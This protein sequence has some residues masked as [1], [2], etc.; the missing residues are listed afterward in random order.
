MKK[1]FLLIAF[2]ASVSFLFA[3]NAGNK[4]EKRVHWRFEVKYPLNFGEDPKSNWDLGYLMENG[5]KTPLSPI[6]ETFMYGRVKDWGL[7]SASYPEEYSHFLFA[8]DVGKDEFLSH[9]NVGDRKVYSGFVK[10]SYRNVIPQINLGVDVRLF[11]KLFLSLDI[12]GRMDQLNIQEQGYVFTVD[13]VIAGWL[14]LEPPSYTNLVTDWQLNLLVENAIV[15]Y[16][17]KILSYGIIPMCRYEIP[18]SNKISV[19][20]KVGVMIGKIFYQTNLDLTD[21]I[22]YPF[23][24]LKILENNKDIF[25]PSDVTM[26]GSGKDKEFSLLTPIVGLDIGKKFY[27][28]TEVQFGFGKKFAEPLL[29]NSEN[30]IKFPE[31]APAIKKDLKENYGTPQND[32]FIHLDKIRLFKVGLGVRF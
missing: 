16:K 9:F 14:Y 1:I 19:T 8:D 20:P 4:K 13:D 3:Q 15:D 24:Y 11:K 17:A 6:H 22:L 30:Q 23:D 12:F 27:V 10:S 28:T 31:I 5:R 29:Y 7:Q 2:M 32:D 21:R 26:G 18:L 25:Y